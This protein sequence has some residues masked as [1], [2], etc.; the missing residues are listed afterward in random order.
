MRYLLTLLLALALL[1]GHAQLAAAE[2]FI[3]TDPGAGNGTPITVSAGTTLNENLSVPTTGL[4]A[5]D[6]W[7]YVRS[8]LSDGRWSH[9]ERRR[10]FVTNDIAAAEYFFDT[11]PGPGLGVALAITPGATLDESHAI[12][13]TG[14]AAGTHTLYV[15]TQSSTG[16]WSLREARAFFI[17]ESI[18][19]AEYYIDTDPGAGLGT[20]I[21][22]TPGASIDVNLSISS[23][24]LP[25]G[26][27]RIYI[28]SRNSGGKWSF[29]ETRTF[30]VQEQIVQ[31]EYF[32]DT[33][34]GNGNGNALAV[35]N[36]TIVTE[37]AA[38]PV[39]GLSG[40]KHNLYIRTRSN[41]GGWSLV[42]KRSFFIKPT[43]VS[44]EFFVETDPGPGNG[45]A[46]SF[47][48]AEN[49]EFNGSLRLPP[50]IDTG[51]HQLQVR[52]RDENG[53]WGHSE[54]MPI[55]VPAL[56]P[57]IVQ[58]TITDNPTYCIKGQTV[59][60]YE[61]GTSRVI[62]TA[63]T[64]GGLQNIRSNVFVHGAP[65]YQYER[66]ILGRSFLLEADNP[67]NGPITVRLYFTQAELQDLRAATPLVSSPGSL[68]VYQY[69]GPTADGTLDISDA[70]YQGMINNTTFGAEYGS[71]Y[72]QFTVTH[73]SEFWLTNKGAILPAHGLELNGQTAA[74]GNELRWST[75]TQS[76]TD[77]FVLERSTDARNW[78][79]VNRQ[80]AAG[81]NTAQLRYSFSD[82][83]AT[84][85]YYYRIRLADLDG[86]NSYSNVILLRR[87]ASGGWVLAPNPVTTTA[88][89]TAPATPANGPLAWKI[90]D[91]DGRT[92][93]TG[94]WTARANGVYNLPVERL[95]AGA[96]RCLV[97]AA[98]GLQVLPFLK[99]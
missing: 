33:D 42:E 58:Q 68:G 90:V 76:N 89:V 8:R 15:R 61:A 47:A 2:Y 54:A 44:G 41:G 74:G 19:A 92:V 45:Y 14:L 50:C 78:S 77:Y 35:T 62:A 36:G 75:L 51:S 83:G 67:S 72:V 7:L 63:T 81:N 57:G 55:R 64:A 97:Q 46:L 70:T 66:H 24:V 56:N 82:R 27:H 71:Y 87:G 1:P 28:R 65:L 34:P 31:A 4:A 99:Q 86:R 52:T 21:A 49:A 13:T 84:A 32:F 53:A 17:N 88:R 39:T 26:S 29:V 5:G 18:V 79:E 95:A 69:E 16:V 59:F 20:P 85:S 60:F 93:A 3:D 22:V 43:V 40:G 6:H 12:A 10:F 38:L 30:Y 11:D 73:F 48:P 80:A 96:Y 25:P 94:Q 91:A 98:D 9:A 37:S 23:G